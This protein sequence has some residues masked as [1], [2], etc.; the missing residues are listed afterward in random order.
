MPFY[1]KDYQQRTGWQ[2]GPDGLPVAECIQMGSVIYT[3][4]CPL[5]GCLHELRGARDGMTV[6][7][8]CLVREFATGHQIPGAIAGWKTL[9]ENWIATRPDAPAHTQV[10]VK[11]VDLHELTQRLTVKVLKPKR[12]R[13]AKAA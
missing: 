11:L 1:V 5:C 8:R 2:I 12:S 13:K 7:P 4:A 3:A 6:T 10:V 9:Y